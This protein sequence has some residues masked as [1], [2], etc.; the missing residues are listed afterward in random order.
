[1]TIFTIVHLFRRSYVD[2]VL[3]V[4]ERNAAG[5]VLKIDP[6]Q[7]MLSMDNRLPSAPALN[8]V[9]HGSTPPE[10][11]LPRS[12]EVDDISKKLNE[13]DDIVPYTR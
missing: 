7:F 5:H 10:S 4:A 11:S 2:A 3:T 12:P 13:P 8:E 1:M 9:L 6:S